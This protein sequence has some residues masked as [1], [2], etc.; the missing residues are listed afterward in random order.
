MGHWFADQGIACLT[1]D[2]RGVGESTAVKC[3]DRPTLRPPICASLI[4]RRQPIRVALHCYGHASLRLRE[5]LR[6][7]F[8][9]HPSAV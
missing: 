8:Y 6:P 5:V 3:H 2:K 4:L 7:G 1:Y 9:S